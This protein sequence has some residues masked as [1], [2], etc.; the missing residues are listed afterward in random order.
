M[1]S[2][3]TLAL[4]LATVDHKPSITAWTLMEAQQREALHHSD[5]P[6]DSQET[7]LSRAGWQPGKRLSR[8][9]SNKTN[10]EFNFWPSSMSGCTAEQAHYLARAEHDF[11][12]LSSK[13]TTCSSCPLN[14]A[15]LAWLKPVSWLILLL[16]CLWF[17]GHV[18]GKIWIFIQRGLVA[19]RSRA[20]IYIE[21]LRGFQWLTTKVCSTCFLR[22]WDTTEF[23]KYSVCDF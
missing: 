11:F 1:A 8:V 15:S 12:N 2:A 18:Y 13:L 7:H 3:A 17:E 14:V 10:Y 16:P 21:A 20:M 9:R 4:F 22:A 23:S 19:R 6:R 5:K